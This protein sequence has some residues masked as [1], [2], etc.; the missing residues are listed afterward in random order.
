[1][2]DVF[3][4]PGSLEEESEHNINFEEEDEF[5]T[6]DL[7]DAVDLFDQMRDHLNDR[8]EYRPPLMRDRLL[9]LHQLAMD[10]YPNGD[11]K[12]LTQLYATAEDLESIAFDLMMQAEKIHE[13][14]EKLTRT[15]PE[16]LRGY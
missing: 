3:E 10:A 5:D 2:S 1:M 13:I 9:E 16:G 4:T 6:W 12:K 8:D 14:L 7:L 11:Q 15:E